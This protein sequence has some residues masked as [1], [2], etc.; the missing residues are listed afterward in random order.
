MRRVGWVRWE[1][2]RHHSIGHG[3]VVTNWTAMMRVRHLLG[4]IGGK[5]VVRGWRR[6]LEVRRGTADRSSPAEPSPPAGWQ[7][8]LRTV[9]WLDG[10][11]LELGGRPT[12]PQ[13]PKPPG[14]G[15]RVQGVAR[16][17]SDPP[18]SRSS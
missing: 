15:S 6:L 7:A 9:R 13:M 10:G 18:L 17:G 1:R 8:V 5:R 4:R 3:S 14:A 2:V 11:R 16:S 12:S